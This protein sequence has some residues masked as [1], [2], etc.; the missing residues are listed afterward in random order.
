MLEALFGWRIM[1]CY[2]YVVGEEIFGDRLERIHFEHVPNLSYAN[3]NCIFDL[4]SSCRVFWKHCFPP[5]RESQSKVEDFQSRHY[6][7][8]QLTSVWVQVAFFGRFEKAA[9]W[10]LLDGEAI[11]IPEDGRGS[12][13]GWLLVSQSEE[14]VLPAAV[15]VK[16]ALALCTVHHLQ[17]APAWSRQCK[18]AHNGPL[19]WLPPL[20][21]L[22]SSCR[23][24]FV[25]G[26]A[27]PPRPRPGDQWAP[28]QEGQS[29]FDAIMLALASTLLLSFTAVLALD[30]PAEVNK[31]DMVDFG[32]RV[33]R[34]SGWLSIIWSGSG[35]TW[36]AGA[37][38][39][40]TA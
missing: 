6:F 10:S 23:A 33:L 22:Q 15:A 12:P 14:P 11:L 2:T 38:Q 4:E 20:L 24:A 30:V 31:A 27:A 28:W 29:L 9:R 39:L 3:H 13:K 26:G 5:N 21:G 16:C 35:Y 7:L 19:W 34:K 37:K 32:G 8:P 18:C 25:S 17:V 36:K 40:T 1:Q